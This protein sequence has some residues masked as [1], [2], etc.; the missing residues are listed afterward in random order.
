[1]DP[2]LYMLAG[3]FALLVIAV[4][5]ALISMLRTVRAG[6]R[7]TQGG[8]PAPPPEWTDLPP[9][10]ERTFDPSLDGLHVEVA[11]DSPS[12]SLLTPLRTGV[13]RPP[14]S[15]APAHELHSVALNRRIAEHPAPRTEPVWASTVPVVAPSEPAPVPSAVAAPPSTPVPAAQV[16][17]APVAAPPSVPRVDATSA[18]QSAAI[19]RRPHHCRRPL[20]CLCHPHYR[21]P[22]SGHHARLGSRGVRAGGYLPLARPERPAA[23]RGLHLRAP[24]GDCTECAI[25]HCSRRSAERD[26]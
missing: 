6:R 10:T 9:A 14:E 12:A 25:G 4:T 1:M 18:P 17:H 3:T 23:R 15:P 2:R 13:W 7:A 21:R 11:H 22:R 19:S 24:R 16:V 5:V 8:P 26:A 20:R